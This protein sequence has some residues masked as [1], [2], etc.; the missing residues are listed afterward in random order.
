MSLVDRK[1]ALRVLGIEVLVVAISTTLVLLHDPTAA[2]SF[3]YG[4]VISVIGHAYFAFK[5][6]AYGGA[7]A[8]KHILRG[9]YMGEAGKF[10]ITVVLFAAAFKTVEN[11]VPG[12]LVAGFFLGLL[13]N[14]LAPLWTKSHIQR[15]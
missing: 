13:V 5:V 11:L 14:R 10:A 8:V 3:A 1:L 12:Y 6:F 9:F 7:R 4:G 15:N 2:K